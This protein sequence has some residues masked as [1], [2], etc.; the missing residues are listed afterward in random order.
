[1]AEI[2]QDY[3]KTKEAFISGNSIEFTDEEGYGRYLD[4]NFLHINFNNLLKEGSSLT[5]VEYLDKFDRLYEIPYDIKQ[6]QPY[7]E[8]L[9]SLRDYLKDFISRS[10]PLSDFTKSELPVVLTNFE[11]EWSKGTFP[12]WNE[13]LIFPDS[14]IDNNIPNDQKKSE[15]DYD[16]SHVE[17]AEELEKLGNDELKRILKSMGLK[18]GGSLKEKAVRLFGVKGKKIKDLDAHFFPISKNKKSNA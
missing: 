4:L 3:A 7:D 12:G 14:S 8:Y 2:F 10:R 18:C 13:S 9:S 1:M 5:Y 15:K 16:L 17:N 11:N 6:K